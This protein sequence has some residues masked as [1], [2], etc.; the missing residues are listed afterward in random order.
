MINTNK[1]IGILGGGQLAMMM[2]ESAKK[3]GA[4]DITVLDPIPNCPAS[5]VG[6]KQIVGSFQDYDKIIELAK[7]VDVITWDIESVNVDALHSVEIN[8]LAKVIPDA[9]CLDIVQDKYIQATQLEEFIQ[10]LHENVKRPKCY[11]TTY[12]MTSVWDDDTSRKFVV[13]TKK[14]GYDGKGVWIMKSIEELTNLMEKHNIDPKNLFVEEFIDFEKE[15]AI[16][17]YYDNTN[18][19]Y[20]TY[21]IVETIQ[22]EGICKKVICPTPLDKH[23]R[24]EIEEL[25]YNISTTFMDGTNSS[26]Y[27]I[28]MFLGKDGFIYVNEISLRVHNSGHYTIEATNCSQFEQ[29]MRIVMGLPLIKPKLIVPYVE[30]TN[31]LAQGDLLDITQLNKSEEGLHWYNKKPLSDFSKTGIP[32]KKNRKI[33]HI[34]K[35]LDL[36]QVPYPLIHIVMGSSSDLPTLRPA[37]DLLDLVHIPFCVDVVSAH[38]S[39]EWMFEYGRNISSW[40]GRVIIAGAGGAAHL[41]GMLASLTDIPVIGVPVPT[42][43]LGGQDS[44]YSIVEMPDGVPVATVGIGKAKNA[45]ILALKIIS[46][47][48]QIKKLQLL[49]K[50]KVTN[51]RENLSNLLP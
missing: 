12:F 4:M 29:Q 49:N 47:T 7:Q 5:F 42:K 38:R 14:G 19:V 33:G 43:N 26:V 27:A 39:P 36:T 37:I 8:G 6:A 20:G 51:Q 21:P 18:D 9:G 11:S 40:C 13:K 17:C 41:P 16:V 24:E 44:L 34:T 48:D 25:T 22:E 45:G 31:I 46:A 32:Y 28:E 23:L 15:L 50:E 35:A 3:L 1:K 30:M 2:I 10:T